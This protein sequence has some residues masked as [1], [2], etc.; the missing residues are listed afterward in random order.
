MHEPKVHI[1]Y[2]NA[3]LVPVADEVYSLTE[4][5]GMVRND[6]LRLI[7]DVEDLAYVATGGTVKAEWDDSVWSKFCLIKH[8]LLDKAGEM[9][10]LP[11][12]LI[13]EGDANGQDLPEETL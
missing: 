8:K 1:V 3:K 2:R 11:Q 9:E 5:V 10:R 6:L 12:N 4:Y 13:C 7:S